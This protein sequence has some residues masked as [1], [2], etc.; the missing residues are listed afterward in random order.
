MSVAARLA[1]ALRPRWRQ[2]ALALALSCAALA[3]N[4]GLLAIAG[5]L[6]AAAAL[7]PLLETLAFPM[8]AVRVLGV[9]RAL[10][11]YGERLVAHRTVLSL[12][13]DMRVWLFS[14]LAPLVPA[15]TAKR[16][17]GDLLVRLTADLDELQHLYLRIASPLAVA[18]CA[19]CAITA[20]FAIF[21]P[22]LAL[23][24]ALLLLAAGVGVPVLALWCARGLGERQLATR[25]V[26]YDR[27]IEGIQGMPDLL[28]SGRSDDHAARLGQVERE[29][30][31]L[32]MQ[33]A[34]IS[35]LQAALAGA[36]TTLAVVATLA[37]AVTPIDSGHI[38]GVYL[39]FLVLLMLAGFEAVQPLGVAFATLGRSLTAAHRLIDMADA[40]PMVRDPLQPAAVPAR[41]SLCFDH[42]SFSYDPADGP[43]L[44]DV[45]LRVEPGRWIAV[46]GPSGAGKST[47]AA[48]A[49]RFW[50][51]YSGTVLVGGAPVDA[52]LLD[53]L[54]ASFALVG[55]D[56]TLFTDTLRNNLR[57]ARAEAT[58]EQ[59][60]DA[61]AVAQIG[62]LPG[63]LDGWV[64]EQGLTLSGGERQRLAV[65]RAVLKDA[66]I[67]ILDEATANLDPTTE[68]QLLAAVHARMRERA[69]LV[70][71]H[72][73]VGMERMA[74]I[75]VLDRGRVV[76][77]GTHA[78]LSERAGLYREMWEAQEEVF[79]V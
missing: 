33:Q 58:D 32:Q 35:G 54:R 12:L 50:E 38:G 26:L 76:Q 72:R 66:P 73:L 17:S 57:I 37:L 63:G 68:E 47:L 61:L 62:N 19:L 16:R 78:Q 34:R 79:L 2:L 64:G 52:Y 28:I 49:L 10:I 40:E 41:P 20:V 3:A 29:A 67:L 15:V 70:I 36:L 59:I 43:V 11:R 46:V 7:K 14:R 24:A 45:D 39:G 13:A 27:V 75:V 22:V 18:A 1:H 65:A 60:L 9:G 53:D 55:Q 5:Y 6:V 77:R 56:T 44:Q 21:S 74:E 30:G 69:V 23:S 42:V 31:Q 71:T 8:A 51:A 48:L 4:V 25:G